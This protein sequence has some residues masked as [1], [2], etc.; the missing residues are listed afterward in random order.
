[1]EWTKELVDRVYELYER[2]I[3]RLRADVIAVN[4]ALGSSNP[5][6]TNLAPL[7]RLAFEELLK[8][9][10]E[11][12]ERQRLWLRRII[13]G[14]EHEFSQLTAIASTVANG[15]AGASLEGERKTA[16]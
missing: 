6:K 16:S 2:H 7:S 5:A 9:P 12:P 3:D 10:A 4:R 1:M 14:H 15:A 8:Q 13:R 11:D